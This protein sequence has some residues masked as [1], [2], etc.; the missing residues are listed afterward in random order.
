MELT[1]A[2][3]AGTTGIRAIAFNSLL[4]PVAEAARQLTV[5]FPRPGE[6]EQQPEEI[7]RLSLEVLDEVATTVKEHGHQISTLGVTNQRETVLCFDRANGRPVSAALVW[8]DRRGDA[9]CTQRRVAGDEQRVREITGLVLDPYFSG[10]KIQWLIA[11]GAPKRCRQPAIATIDTWLI[12]VLTGGAE[13]GEFLSEPSNASRTLLYDL[14][15]HDWS[16]EMCELIGVD[17]GHLAELR[18]SGD[19]FGVVDA[20]VL[21]A[22]AGVPISAVLGDQQAALFGQ[23]GFS[24]GLVKVTYGT[25]AFVLVN[26]GDERPLTR[27]GLLSTVAWDLGGNVGTTYALEGSAF[28]AGAAI[29]WFR[30]ELGLIERSDQLEALANSVDDSGGVYLVPAFSGLGSP[31]WK[32]S[33]RGTLVGLTGA[34]GRGHLA[35]ALVEALAFQV[36]A[37]TDAFADAHVRVREIRA[38]GGAAAMDLLLELQ[39]RHSR[40]LV[41]RSRSVE[42]TARGAA[43][44]AGWVQGRWSGLDE[45]AAHWSESA[46]F[47]PVATSGDEFAYATWLRACA[48][49]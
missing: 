22:L 15:A 40:C 9:W 12:W 21:P 4:E 23:A 34:S 25:G 49:A 42:A 45:I 10:S 24:P 16:L 3:D 20:R 13:G 41:R 44:L 33:A 35:R 5:A 6:V 30:D 29:Q 39:A 2:L 31:F 8:Q 48:A 37:I 11:D 14:D 28:V 7:A 27:E 38:D 47:E 32:P 18:A 1:L 46:R 17:P 26:A 36:R 19:D 43:S